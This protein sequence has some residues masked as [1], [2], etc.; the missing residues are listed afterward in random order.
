[1]NRVLQGL[2]LIWKVLLG[3]V[4]VGSLVWFILDYSQTR[5]LRNIFS[6]DLSEK[7]EEQAFQDRMRF[8]Q[9]QKDIADNIDLVVNH[10]NVRK[11]IFDLRQRQGNWDK[12]GALPMPISRQGPQ[13]IPRLPRTVDVVLVFDAKERTRE[14]WSRR[15]IILPEKIKKP[16]SLLL[17]GGEK[18]PYLT[19]DKGM[20]YMVINAVL[21]DEQ[22]LPV[23]RIMYVSHI[24]SLFMLK[25][26]G[27]LD[28]DDSITSFITGEPAKVLVS[29]DPVRIPVGTLM[30]EL[31]DDYLVI[32]KTFLDYGRSE[33][34]SGLAAFMPR[35]SF[36][37]LIEPVTGLGRQQRALTVIIISIAF[38]L[39][40]LAVVRTI[41]RLSEKVATF[42]EKYFDAPAQK[43]RNQDEIVQLDDH[44][45]RL[46][47][48]VLRSRGA[49]QGEADRLYQEVEVRKK[50][51]V[52]LVHEKRI[53]EMANRTKSELM[54]N[55]SHELRTPLNAIIGFSAMIKAET[56]GHLNEK[57]LS[58]AKDINN[59]G[60]HLLEL[61]NDILDASAIEAG[62]LGLHEEDMDV[63]NLVNATMRMLKNRA[64][65]GNIRLIKN[66][67]DD[68]PM[69]HA[70]ARRMKQIL[71]NLLSNAI[72]FTPRN[73]KVSIRASLDDAGAHVF[74]IIDTGIGM[75]KAELSEAMSKFGQIDSGLNRKY[76]GTGLGLPLTLGLIDLH[77]GT[78]DI[79]SKKEGGTTVT[80]RFPPHRTVVVQEQK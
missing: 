11:H 54:A 76:E 64:R 8:D 28:Q 6:A 4:L 80:V 27:P 33:L 37:R 2:P 71:L 79:V 78:F 66:I 7:L 23:A 30:S 57:Y 73:G 14:I 29:S 67:D 62:K 56:F 31:E 34:H 12:S 60:Q 5:N 45:L 50:T 68:L 40:M 38:L 24:D 55:M 16:T 74:T 49:L 13:W 65:E 32:G 19:E 21:H 39:L 52:K 17:R 59:S 22:G 53:S 51:E 36:S 77:G 75:N 35:E 43:A 48:E 72:K 58:Y 41:L 9:E 63:D 42:T 47:D 44:F 61:I 10:Y 25:I 18:E 46:M 26:R 15:E 69:L 1:M 70:D 20:L 3:T